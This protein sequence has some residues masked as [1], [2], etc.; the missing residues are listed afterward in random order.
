MSLDRYQM[1]LLIA[2]ITINPTNDTNKKIPINNT[3]HYLLD[4]N[5]LPYS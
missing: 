3:R 4:P 5:T 2:S 1:C